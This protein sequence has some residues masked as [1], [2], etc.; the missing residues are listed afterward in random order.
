MNKNKSIAFWLFAVSLLIAIM[1]VFG[2][3]VRLTRSGLSIVEW[4]VVTGVAPPLSQAAWD[5]AFRQYQQTPE[6][7]QVNVGMGLEEFKSI[8]YVEYGHRL[9]GRIAG[10]AFLVP[11]FVFFARG[12]ILRPRL[13]AFAA[14]DLLFALQGL[15]GW[16]MVES[17]LIDQ[18]RVSHLRLTLH[19]SA[20]LLLLAGCLWLAFGYAFGQPAPTQPRVSPQLRRLSVV[21][22]AV[23]G[24]QIVAGGLVAGLKAGYISDTFPKMLGQWIPDGLWR[25]QPWIAN[26]LANPATVHFQHRWFAFV[27]LGVA[28]ALARRARM[29]LLPAYLRP[30]AVSTLHLTLV[31][32]LLGVGVVAMHM[33]V[34]MASLH[35]AV[36]VAVL[37]AA[38]QV[39]HR[40]FRS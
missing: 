33:P 34:W 23:A 27:V 17:G 25:L 8:Y 2:G 15:L 5:D 9:L 28:A 36:A 19:L 29:E 16:L 37:A 21:F 26:H 31:Q 13:P 22:L 4:N 18:P 38:L 30:A 6:Y 24:L 20:A 14:I 12:A 10:L 1:V 7:L 32:I 11:L 35:Q 3:W 40:A 39:C